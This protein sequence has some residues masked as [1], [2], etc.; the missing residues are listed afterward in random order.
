MQNDQP[1]DF[2]DSFKDIISGQSDFEVLANHPFAVPADHDDFG[3]TGGLIAYG[4]LEKMFGVDL[5]QYEKKHFSHEQF[6]RYRGEYIDN[7]DYPEGYKE[8]MQHAFSASSIA[9]L[10]ADEQA[11]VEKIQDGQDIRIDLFR[12]KAEANGWESL[13]NQL[14]VREIDETTREELDMGFM[15]DLDNPSYDLITQYGVESPSYTSVGC[16]DFVTDT[17]R[18]EWGGTDT[19]TW[20]ANQF[21]D[22]ALSGSDVF[23]A[24]VESKHLGERTGWLSERNLEAPNALKDALAQA[25][26]ACKNL[27]DSRGAVDAPTHDGR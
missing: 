13:D 20:S 14:F 27:N 4:V 17:F 6:D 5:S 25:Q 15:A 24:K 3:D 2:K 21:I 8:L 1:F 7:F 26:E 12:A 11:L 10:T 23:K 9:E 22:N 16:K 19:N 18:N